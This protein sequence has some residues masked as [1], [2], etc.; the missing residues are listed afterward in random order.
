MVVTCPT[1]HLDAM[2][3]GRGS[4]VRL[5]FS[6]NL[7]TWWSTPRSV[8]FT[9]LCSLYWSLGVPQGQSGQARNFSPP[10]QSGSNPE[11]PKHEAIHYTGRSIPADLHLRGRSKIRENCFKVAHY[12]TEIQTR[13]IVGTS[14]QHSCKTDRNYKFSEGIYIASDAL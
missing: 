6:F 1:I 3:A 14:L 13:H 5:Y 4:T 12:S 11:Q 10:P 7:Y 2:A 9:P 8:R